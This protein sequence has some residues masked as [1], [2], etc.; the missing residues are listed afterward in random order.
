MIFVAI[1]GLLSVVVVYTSYAAIQPKL[2]G[3]GNYNISLFK[4]NFSSINPN[5]EIVEF[6]NTTVFRAL[7]NTTGTI[8]LATSSG[9]QY[10]LEGYYRP[11]STLILNLGAQSTQNTLANDYPVSPNNPPIELLCI[12]GSE[13]GNS[14]LEFSIGGDVWIENLVIR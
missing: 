13:N 2:L 5:S 7:D 4:L 9:K 12:M 1:F 14:Q 8:R 3:S 10:C 6:N 11:N